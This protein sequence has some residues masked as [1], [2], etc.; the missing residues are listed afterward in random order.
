VGWSAGL[1]SAT[2]VPMMRTMRQAL[3]WTGVVLAVVGLLVLAR[4][5]AYAGPVDG[6]ALCRDDTISYS[7]HASGTCSWH[8]GVKAWAHTNFLDR[9]MHQH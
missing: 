7:Q 9:V 2:R 1:S 6:S 8:G 3:S 4:A 5:P